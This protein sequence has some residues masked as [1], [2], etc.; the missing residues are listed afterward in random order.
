M[1]VKINYDGA[2]FPNSNMARVRVVIRDSHG[3][4][5][6]SCLKLIPSARSVEEIEAQAATFALSFAMDIGF[7]RAVLEG[8]SWTVFRALQN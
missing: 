5:L 3:C 6:A 7:S 4:V 1:L 8:D 2:V